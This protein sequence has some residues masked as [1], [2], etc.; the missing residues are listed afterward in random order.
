MSTRS[1]DD[2]MRRLP[3]AIRA[4][5]DNHEALLRTIAI[6]RRQLSKKKKLVPALR[7]YEQR[8]LDLATELAIDEGL[9]DQLKGLYWRPR[10]DLAFGFDATINPDGGIELAPVEPKERERRKRKPLPPAPADDGGKLLAALE[11]SG[12]AG[13]PARRVERQTLIEQS[14]NLAL[15]LAL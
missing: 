14:T 12:A 8:R 6:A 1:Y 13:S 3:V 10:A 2:A 7:E 15:A 4:L 9:A 11:E 5:R